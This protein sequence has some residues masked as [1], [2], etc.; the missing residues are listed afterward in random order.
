MTPFANTY[1]LF[2]PIKHIAEDGSE[3]WFA[4]ELAD[5]L[6]YAKW[7]NFHKVIDKAMIA[8][9]KNGYQFTDYKLTCYACLL[10][11]QNADSRKEMEQEWEN[12]RCQIGTSSENI[13][14]GIRYLP[15][16]F[17]EQGVAMLSGLLNSDIAIDT[18]IRIM[19]AFVFVRQ[20]AL[21][22]AELNR[23]LED[24]MRETN[25]QFNEV[26][27]ALNELAAQKRLSAKPRRSIG[28]YTKE[29][30]NNHEDLIE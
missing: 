18:N 10:I 27:Q 12:L 24:F 30:R 4:R 6:E 9:Q 23:K 2:E 3:Y 13:H 5:V 8:C 21:G 17:T 29:Q 25:M 22:Y 28:F 19:R 14:G 26:Y 1:P 20:Y 7:S 11:V 16:V 15:Y